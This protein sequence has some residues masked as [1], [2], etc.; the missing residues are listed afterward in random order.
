[1]E[2]I[3]YAAGPSFKQGAELPVMPNVNLYL[4]ICRLLG[5]Q[6]APNDGDSTVIAPL[7]RE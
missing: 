2:A 7:F 4:I 5:I 3:F 6:P 1:M